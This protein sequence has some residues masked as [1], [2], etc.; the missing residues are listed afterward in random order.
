MVPG[1]VGLAA[2]Q[3]NLFVNG[4]LASSLGTGAVSWLDYA[5][6]L[7]YMPIGLFGI[8]IA[9]ASLPNISRHV[10]GND[11]PSVRNAVSRS[12]RLMLM[13]NVPATV[14][15]VVL[16]TPIVSLIFERGQ[17]TYTDTL[18]TT[19]ALVW[20]APGLVGY[21]A[22]KLASPVFYALGNS[23]IPVVASTL[24][25]AV[26]IILSLV[27]VRW[28]GHRGLA[29]G[30]SI[31]ALVNAGLLVMLLRSRLNG[32][33]DRRVV[34]AFVK[35]SMASALMAA[36]A[37]GTERLLRVP[38]AGSTVLVQVP[39]VFGAIGAG[40]AVLGLAAH[41]LRIEEF[42]QL[43]RRLTGGETPVT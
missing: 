14:G 25:V 24:S 39:R 7:M 6:R 22:V 34:V 5:F 28:M 4:W 17:F 11:I 26:N 33:D 42:T 32:L 31:A 21:S 30:T 41:F 29:L 13:L 3:I 20:Y 15:L 10:A 36:A 37:Y 8:S 35:I 18:G 12:L 9:T 1:V 19:A 2:V 27:L 23:R 43:T 16:A 40:M 38:L